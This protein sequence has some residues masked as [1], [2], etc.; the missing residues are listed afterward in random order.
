MSSCQP[1]QVPD[2]KNTCGISN[3]K[4]MEL[5]EEI[6]VYDKEIRIHIM[7]LNDRLHR[8]TF[9]TRDQFAE[10]IAMKFAGFQFAVYGALI[11][12]EHGLLYEADLRSNRNYYPEYIRLLTK[13]P[14]LI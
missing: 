14:V 12:A 1:I 6:P 13:H 11:P 5:P 3:V 8:R 9:M 7:Y 10:A 4:I 2:F